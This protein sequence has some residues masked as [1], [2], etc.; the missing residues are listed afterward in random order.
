MPIKDIKTSAD[1]KQFETKIS[2]ENLRKYSQELSAKSITKVDFSDS[3]NTLILKKPTKDEIVKVFGDIHNLIYR[4]EKKTPTDG[5]Y[6]FVKLF[7]L[8]MKN[9]KQ[10]NDKQSK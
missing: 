8:K 5:F 2:L 10:L 4:K 6:E 7:C 1:I 9:D 3:T